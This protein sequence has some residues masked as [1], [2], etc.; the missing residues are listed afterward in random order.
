M[1]LARLDGDH[2]MKS[3]LRSWFETEVRQLASGFAQARVNY[4]VSILDV[5]TNYIE[6]RGFKNTT[7]VMHPFGGICVTWHN[8]EEVMR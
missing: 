1:V 6:M 7:A 5:I 4:D 8:F 2:R 3:I